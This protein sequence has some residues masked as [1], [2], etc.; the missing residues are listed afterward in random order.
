M[1]ALT[2]AVW[3]FGIVLVLIIFAGG[4]LAFRRYL[5]ERS[6]GTVDCALRIPA[7]TGAWR[8]GVLS[9]Q[10]DSLRWHGALGV[11][12]RPEHVFH[13]RALAVVSRRP[14]NPSE[15]VTLGMDRIVVEVS[16]KPPADASGSPAGEHVELAMT[17]QALTGFLS[18]LEASPPGSHLGDFT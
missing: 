5:L 9:Y 11:L 17:D 15:T 4:V 6:G 18:W 7:G 12:L 14:A 8:L 10:R 1:G 2:D 3:I 16:V 13:R